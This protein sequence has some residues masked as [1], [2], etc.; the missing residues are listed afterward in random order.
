MILREFHKDYST[1]REFVKATRRLSAISLEL[2]KKSNAFRLW[3]TRYRSV[4]S[5]GR[6][7]AVCGIPLSMPKNR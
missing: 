5:I 6:E 1:W 3:I 2:A 4:I 7:M